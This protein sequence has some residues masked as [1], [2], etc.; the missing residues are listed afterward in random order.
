MT[1]KNSTGSTFMVVLITCMLFS[2]MCFIYE[3]DPA[4]CGYYE[5][6]HFGIVQFNCYGR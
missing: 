6:L 5:D 4:S 1:I 2:L 3:C